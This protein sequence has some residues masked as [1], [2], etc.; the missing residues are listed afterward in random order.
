[1]LEVE[2]K[3]VV[4]KRVVSADCVVSSLFEERLS[5]MRSPCNLIDLNELLGNESEFTRINTWIAVEFSSVFFDIG[6][7]DIPSPETAFSEWRRN[8]FSFWEF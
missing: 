6:Y 8:G 7:V 5:A 4:E 2:L 3:L 1:M